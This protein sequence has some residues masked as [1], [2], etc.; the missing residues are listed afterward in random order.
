MEDA[1]T[2]IPFLLEYTIRKIY[3]KQF[4]PS[5]SYTIVILIQGNV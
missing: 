5:A 2:I 1:Y 3:W 4:C